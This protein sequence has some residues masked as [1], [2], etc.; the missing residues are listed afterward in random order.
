LNPIFESNDYNV[1]YTVESLVRNSFTMKYMYKKNIVYVVYFTV[2]LKLKIFD[3]LE[4]IKGP[5]RRRILKDI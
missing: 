5:I 3:K 2:Y 1:D 4:D